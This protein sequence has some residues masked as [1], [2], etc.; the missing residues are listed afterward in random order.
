MGFCNKKFMVS[1]RTQS[2]WDFCLQS[3]LW[4]AWN[5]L[6]L[7]LLCSFT[8][9]QFNFF[10]GSTILNYCWLLPALI[11]WVFLNFFSWNSSIKPKIFLGGMYSW[12]WRPLEF[13][14]SFSPKD[15]K[16]SINLI[17]PQN[18]I[19]RRWELD[20]IIPV[21]MV[22]PGSESLSNCHRMPRPGQKIQY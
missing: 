5:S 12:Q 21:V 14:L 8:T 3:C 15:L 22:T 16:V 20:N 18:I 2:A 17:W 1:C 11:I 13:V 9:A 6:K 19:I 4:P 10:L 7:A